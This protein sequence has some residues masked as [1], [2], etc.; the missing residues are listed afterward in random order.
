MFEECAMYI[1]EIT[2]RLVL[3][4]RE[5]ADLKEMNRRYQNRSEHTPMDRAAYQSREL[6]LTGIKDELAF[7]MRRAA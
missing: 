5:L 6:R 7:M 4:K 3:L 1:T 2:E